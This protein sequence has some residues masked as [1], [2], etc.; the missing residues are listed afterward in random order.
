[1]PVAKHP[2]ASSLR[3]SD[4]GKVVSAREAVR[5]IRDGDTVA[6]GGFV[7]IGFA[8]NIA[9]ALEE[10]FLEGEQADVHGL[11]S[12]RNLTL[13]YAAGQGDG[14]ERGL[15]HFGH[16]GLVSRVLGG[17]WGL[18]PKLQ[19]LAVANRIEAYNLPQGVITHLFRD[20]AA[21]K[22]GTIT[23]VGLGTFVDPRFGGGKLN[24]KT[25]TDVV[26]LMEIDGQEY[27]FYKAFPINVGIIRGTTAD[28]DGNITMEKEA[29]T[30]EAQ[31]IAMATRNS[32]GTVIVQV[33]RIAERGTLNPRQVKI[34]G[35]LVDCV[36][37]AEKPE[38]HLQTFAEPYSAAFAGEIKVPMSAIPPMPMSERKIIARRAALELKAN[39]VVNLG[40]GMPEGVANVAAE[41]QIIDLMTLTAE[42]GVI[43]GVPA[44]GLSFG[45]ATNAQ[46]II[47]QPSQ[48]DFY[49][50]GGLD[51]AFLGLA[52]ADRQGN[53]NVSKFGPRLAGAGGFI[54][55]SQN[56]KKVVFVGTFTAGNL[57]VAVDA[58]K[59]L[60][61]E[62]GKARKFVQE[63]E[64]RTFSGPQAAKWGKTV[65][66][67]TERCVFRL[68]A[69]G[70]E[71][72]EIAP[73]VDLQRDILDKMDFMPIMHA[74][75]AL[76]DSRIF[77]EEPMNIRPEMLAIPLSERLTYE[78]EK[79]LFFLNF[80]GLTVRSEADIERIQ[81]AVEDFLAP[82]GHK[83]FAIVNYDRF[84]IT[85]ELVD[86]Y[87]GMVRG[88]VE[89]FYHDVTRYTS[90]TF[91]RVKLGE[92][93]TKAHVAPH[94]YESADEAVAS[95]PAPG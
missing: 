38:Y 26:R 39:A 18:V 49:D 60:I 55:I 35:I 93:L 53:L 73:G 12:P 65:L 46:A 1:M 27:L 88:V 94:L 34:P 28:P 50:G 37:V 40:I 84:S 87:M 33:E 25:T 52:Q 70:L 67:V 32:G 90:N 72:I 42:P 10:L 11:G 74:E 81:H 86:P 63:V 78:P 62:D 91:M 68:C 61:L 23:R 48:F 41:E 57:D 8:E 7:G 2:M 77:H 44:G 17:H 51:I 92:A 75:P 36:V 89:R 66:Y 30:L 19:Q 13:V 6:T 3:A 83:V 14:K 95:L 80:E 71:L 29:L 15:N 59:L 16:D 47:D 21:G 85:P 31:A 22:P 58:G 20:I 82:I 69:E 4:T 56:A 64:H 54:N 76:M 45:A 5:L 9:V 43:G 24:E 79:N